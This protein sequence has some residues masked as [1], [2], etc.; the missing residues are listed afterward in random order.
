MLRRITEEVKQLT[1]V[2]SQ[3]TWMMIHPVF[4]AVYCTVLLVQ[5]QL[6][7]A[8]IFAMFGYGLGGVSLIRLIA[9]DFKKVRPPSHPAVQ[10]MLYQRA[11]D[12]ISL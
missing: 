2:L 3:M 11:S 6:P 9:P 5:V 4:D 12:C 7:T 1:M 8:A 10:H